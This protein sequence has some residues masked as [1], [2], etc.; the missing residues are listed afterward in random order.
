MQRSELSLAALA[1]VAIPGLDIYQA[2]FTSAPEGFNAALILDSEARQWV[3][4][5]PLD[6]A[7]GAALEAETAL[8]HVLAQYVDSGSLPFVVPRPAGYTPLLEGG[9]AVVHPRVTGNPLDLLRLTPGP[10]ATASLGRAIGAIHCLPARIVEDAGFPVYSAEQYRE[11]RLAELDEGASTGRVPSHLLRRWE[12]AL[13]NVALWRFQP[14]VTHNNLSEEAIIMSHGQ[15]SGVTDWSAAQVGDP[16]DDLAWLIAGAPE[17]CIDTIFEAYQMRR[18]EALDPHLIDRALLASELALLKWLLH[19][20]RR[21]N[22]E[23]VEDAE[24]MLADLVEATSDTSTG[25]FAVSTARSE[26]KKPVVERMIGDTG[27]FPYAFPPDARVD[28]PAAED[29]ED[30]SVPDYGRQRP[31]QPYADIRTEM[32]SSL[33]EHDAP[34]QGTP[35][36]G[37]KA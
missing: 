16:A 34:T 15:V 30:A 22:A 9:R 1:T 4:R 36:E 14:V 19:G 37:D 12:N 8:L 25:T 27:Q 3:V 17:E 20:V 10:G 33:K 5:A 29:D 11:R 35:S 6:A 24:I 26:S 32:L 28:K 2:K 31:P 21:N 7:A 18:G 13:E 23:V